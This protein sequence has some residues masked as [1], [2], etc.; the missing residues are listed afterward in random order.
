[1]EA[2]DVEGLKPRI[3]RPPTYEEEEIH[4][5]VCYS[6]VCLNTNELLCFL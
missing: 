1:M 2:L 6:L 4:Q 5:R 3:P